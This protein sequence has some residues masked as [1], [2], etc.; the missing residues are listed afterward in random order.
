MSGYNLVV[1]YR[2]AESDVFEEKDLDC[3]VLTVK[4]HGSKLIEA[5][6]RPVAGM[7]KA[8]GVHKLDLYNAVMLEEIISVRIVA[9]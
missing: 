3:S 5:W 6:T 7:A 8:V 9:G 4:G 2:N 1:T